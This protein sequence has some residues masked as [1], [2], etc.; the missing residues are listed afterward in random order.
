MS[1]HLVYPT[2]AKERD[3]DHI[4]SNMRQADLDEIQAVGTPDPHEAL[5]KGYKDS[6]PYCYSGISRGVPVAMFGVV[7]FEDEPKFGSIWLLGTDHISDDIPIGFLRW[8]KKFFPTVM[9]P[10]DMVCN[11]VDKRNEVHIKW[12]KWLGFSF[13]REIVHGPE[14]RPFYEFVRL[15]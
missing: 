13:I 3:I 9:E 10:Y 8:S 7:P 5:T 6:K 2:Y 1:S 12:I 4:A 15:K 11:V 14:K